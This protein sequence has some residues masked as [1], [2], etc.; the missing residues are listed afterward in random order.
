MNNNVEPEFGSDIFA[1]V[2]YETVRHNYAPRHLSRRELR[3]WHKARRWVGTDTFDRNMAI[4]GIVVAGLVVFLFV[5]G[6]IS[7]MVVK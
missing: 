6:I 4:G 1:P 7:M 5:V 3:R 2:E